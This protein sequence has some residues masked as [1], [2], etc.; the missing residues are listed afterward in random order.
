MGIWCLDALF[1]ELAWEFREKCAEVSHFRFTPTQ[2]NNP[3][4]HLQSLHAA[5]QRLQ[6]CLAP[7]A[8]KAWVFED[9]FTT[10]VRGM[11]AL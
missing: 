10:L 11:S 8:P 6:F 4:C 7:P 1:R 9:D 2:K 5:L 3:K